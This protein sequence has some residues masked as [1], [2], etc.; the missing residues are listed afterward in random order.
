MLT[1]AIFLFIKTTVKNSNVVKLQYQIAVLYL[2]IF[3]VIYS[4]DGKAHFLA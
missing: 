3:Y 4:Y 2:Y 1:K